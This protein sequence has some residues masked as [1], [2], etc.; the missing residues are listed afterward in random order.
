MLFSSMTFIFLFLPLVITLYH[1]APRGL[2]NSIL[3][4]ASILFYAWGE[5]VYC[6]ILFLIVAANYCAALLMSR[7]RSCRTAFLVTALLINFGVLFHFKYMDFLASNLAGFNISGQNWFRGFLPIG[8]SFYTFQ[9]VSYL[10][11]VYRQEIPA[12][13]NFFKLSL[14]VALFPQM[15]AGPILKYHDIAPQIDHRETDFALFAYGV[16]RFILGLAKKMLIA[17]VL[18]AAAD[19]FFNIKG[20]ILYPSWMFWFGAVAYMF[21]IYYDFSGYSDMAIGLGSMF[22]FRFPENFNYP[23][24]SRTITEFWRRWH[25]SLSSWFKEYLYIPLGGNRVSRGR[26][27]FNLLIVF[28][29]T[30]MWHGASWNFILWGLWHGF[31]I[32]LEK[33]TGL[34]EKKLSRA[35]RFLAHLYTLFVVLFG[36]VLFRADNLAEACSF[37]RHMFGIMDGARP[38]LNWRV[39]FD[40]EILGALILAALCSGPV[41]S[42][43][44]AA[45]AQD[46]PGNDVPRPKIWKTV[47]VNS[48]LM[49]LF[50][51]SVTKIAASTYNPFI[52]FR[53]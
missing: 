6:Q 32:I 42:R 36:W 17:N 48:W 18:G 16:K 43:M 51:L 28:L 34:H 24:I 53:F 40:N 5:P 9:S 14:F 31:F 11:D 47:L 15:I 10:I 27:Y 37:F 46:G 50:V 1:T 35:G 33:A 13:R 22:G 4:A 12:Q 20:G 30:G 7:F 38:M 2:G 49:V 23:Y 21:Q 39:F 52:Y 19:Q 44:I 26:N 41:F 8:I 29:A 3:L 25:I 45:P